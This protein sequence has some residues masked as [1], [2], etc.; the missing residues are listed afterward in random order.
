MSQ[1]IDLAQVCSL[2]DPTGLE[3]PII[4]AADSGGSLD[5]S[6]IGPDCPPPV[7]RSAATSHIRTPTLALSVVGPLVDSRVI[8]QLTVSPSGPTTVNLNPD[9]YDLVHSTASCTSCGIS[10]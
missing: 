2:A 1:F 5:K 7:L 10:G 3:V 8:G 9:S 6:P 4:G